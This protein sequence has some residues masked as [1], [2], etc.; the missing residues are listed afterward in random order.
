MDS[1][2]GG[3]I[4]ALYR[5]VYA[6][7]S[8]GKRTVHMIPRSTPWTATTSYSQSTVYPRTGYRSL[9]LGFKA[10]IPA[11]PSAHP[12]R[13]NINRSDTR[14]RVLVNDGSGIHSLIHLAP[15]VSL[16]CN[17]IVVCLVPGADIDYW[18]GCVGQPRLI[19]LRWTW[20]EEAELLLEQ[21]HCHPALIDYLAAY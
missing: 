12:T 21:T 20:V 13:T 16:S 19:P 9:S 3:V 11:G 10:G 6:F 1:Y 2:I 5:D 4:G 8:A 18:R 17:C 15:H 7:A 14:P